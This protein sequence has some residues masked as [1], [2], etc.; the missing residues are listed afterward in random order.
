ME[1]LYH[2]GVKGQQWG[3]KHGPPYPVRPGND[4]MIRKGTKLHRL[5]VRDESAAKGHAYVTYL[6][7][8]VHRY[9]G[10]FA[11]NL[12]GK[13]RGGKVY[14][15]EMTALEDLRSPSQERRIKEFIELYKKDPIIA[16]ELGNYEK[17]RTK[18]WKP[19]SVFQSKF[20][21][22]DHDALV[23]KG[24]PE[25][26][27]SLGGNEYIRN[28]YFRQLS[29]KGYNY[30]ID[31]CDAGKFGLEPAIIFN[32]TRTTKY[33]GRTEV[34]MKEILSIWTKEGTKIKK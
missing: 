24:Y 23:K 30:V 2:H 1:I 18:S 33:D 31:D 20:S 17:Q 26:V 4:V 32:R 7:S 25:F 12:K 5:S 11:A 28:K 14:D 34:P 6:N 8:D 27:K 3:V 21:R 16:K 29:R 22:L 13:T 10:F 19:K 15:I 9:K